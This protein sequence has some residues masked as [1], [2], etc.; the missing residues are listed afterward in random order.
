[1]STPDGEALAVWLVDGDDPTLVAEGVRGLVEELV[2]DDDR[3]L[4]VED[5]EGEEVDLGVVADACQTP[6]FLAARRVVVV[7]DAG[8]FST[9][10]VTPLLS[11]LETPL[12]TTA[13]VLAAGGGRLAPKLLAAVKAHG[14]VRSTA[15]G[16]DTRS[17][18]HARIRQSPVSLDGE[19]EALLEAHLGADVSRLPAILTVLAA[20]HGDGARLGAGD[21]APYL[22]EAGSGAPWDLTDAIDD[23]DND[24]A[25]AQLH[26][27]LTAGERHPLV[28]LATLHRH[29]AGLLRL[30]GPEVVTEAQAA[31]ALG[32]PS[33]RSTF[34]AKKALRASRRWGS[35]SIA[36]G[37]ALVARAELDL[38]GARDLPDEVVLEVLVARLCRLAR[39]GG[40]GRQPRPRA[41]ARPAGR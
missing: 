1:M 6:P 29:V 4:A 11:Y 32:I 20:A 27:L 22:G 34:P 23:G 33:G 39:T 41:G 16:R 28:V 21:V 5:F 38:K 19:A 2:G 26:R 25:L 3:T 35:A 36:E 7:R 30:D 10:E 18:V 13:L 31:E 9:E 24:R 40:A 37:I 8:R 14:H 15:V 12:P 17:W